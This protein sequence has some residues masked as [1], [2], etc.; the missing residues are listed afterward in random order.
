M[1]LRPNA[2]S[3]I[4]FSN[5]GRT[6]KWYSGTPIFPFGYGLHYTT[7]TPTITPPST[8]VY[9]IPSLLANSTAKYPDLTPF[10]SLPVT[11]T[12]TGNV[13]SDYVTLLFLSGQFGPQPYPIK[14]L[15]AYQRLHNITAGAVQTAT[16]NLTLASLARADAEGDLVLWPGDYRVAVDVD[17]GVGW[18]FT[19]TGEEVKLDSWPAQG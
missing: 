11:I 13:T 3:N 17:G 15:I 19:L 4:S 16:L 18:N 10:L 9:S 12:N 14:S 7:F 8:S 6:Y 2:S 5:P 1:N